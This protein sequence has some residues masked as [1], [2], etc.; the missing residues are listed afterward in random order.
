M[1]EDPIQYEPP[2]P[3]EILQESYIEDANI[4][5]EELANR[6]GIQCSTLNNILNKSGDITPYLALQLS[7]VLSTSAKLWLNL[8]NTWDLWKEQEKHREEL[9]SIQPFQKLVER[10]RHRS[11]ASLGS[12]T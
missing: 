2:H 5:V 10:Q 9:I 3:G 8:Q 6:M 1:H 12:L 4:T 7:I 11:N